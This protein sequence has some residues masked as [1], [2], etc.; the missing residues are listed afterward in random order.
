M[1]GTTAHIAEPSFKMAQDLAEL[2]A[3][4]PGGQLI[5]SFS[6][7]VR[8][9]LARDEGSPFFALHHMARGLVES[10]APLYVMW[11]GTRID[12]GW[13]DTL[14]LWLAVTRPSRRSGQP[15]YSPR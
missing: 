7:E 10:G 12:W 6:D 3:R 15:A 4:C 1:D 11:G 2:A 13:S 8:A 9:D 5:E 14:A